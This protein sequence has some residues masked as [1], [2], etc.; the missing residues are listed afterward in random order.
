[1]K[2]ILKKYVFLICILIGATACEKPEEGISTQL[3]VN[4]DIVRFRIYQNQNIY[5]D[6]TIDETTIRV[7]IPADFD[8]T[9]IHPEIL[10]SF[11]AVVSPASGE[12]QDFSNPVNYTVTSENREVTKT[13]QIIV[14]N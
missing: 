14:N 11:G 2:Q 5:F 12:A 10:L 7:K 3:S 9:R 13:Y 6:G 8:K 1:M 4:A